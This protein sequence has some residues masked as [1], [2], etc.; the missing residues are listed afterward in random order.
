MF[1]YEIIE[2]NKPASLHRKP[3]IKKQKNNKERQKHDGIPLQV[4]LTQYQGLLAVG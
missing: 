2:Y 4:P 1:L 3:V